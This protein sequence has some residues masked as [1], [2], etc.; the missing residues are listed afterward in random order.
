MMAITT[1]SSTSVKNPFLLL[2]L[3]SGFVLIFAF[4][5]FMFINKFPVFVNNLSCIF[6][7]ATI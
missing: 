5:F 7:I 3:L 1:R 4:P 6:P 2:M